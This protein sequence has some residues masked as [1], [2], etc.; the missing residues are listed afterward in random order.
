[1]G[2]VDGELVDLEDLEFVVGLLILEPDG[3]DVHPLDERTEV[4]EVVQVLL[5][6]DLLCADHRDRAHRFR[7]LVQRRLIRVHLIII[8]S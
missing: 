5:L 8:I 6:L 1:M 4:L 3:V 7:E 2:V